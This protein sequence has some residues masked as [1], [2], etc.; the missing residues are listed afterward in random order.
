[1]TQLLQKF[2]EAIWT[3]DGPIVPFLTFPYSTRMAVIRLSD[4]GLFI[5]S[6]IALSNQLQREIDTLGPVHFL[7]SPNKLHHLY[8]AEWKHAYPQ[9]QLI[10]SPGLSNK[11]KDLS[12]D[13]ELG[14]NT[15]LAWSN[16]IDQSIMYGSFLTEVV[17]FHHAS[18]TVLFADLL[19]NFAADWFKGWRGVIARLDG[20]CAPNPGAPR[21][22]RA[23]FWNR[24]AAREAL[25]KILSWPIE[26]VVIAHGEMVTENGLAFVQKAFA[27]L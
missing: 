3:A 18:G 2:A 26:R 25:S 5:W 10:A 15:E 7:V 6:P 9:A 19:Q 21:E 12:F 23:S 13:A 14:K 27:W 11:R 16:T 1:M 24:K 22:W 8:L 17:F 4:G 20:I